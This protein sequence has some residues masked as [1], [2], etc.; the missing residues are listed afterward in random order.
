MFNEGKKIQAGELVSFVKVHPFRFQER[1]LTVKPS[2]QAK[3]REIN[4]DDYVRN[5]YSS[6]S[7][8]FQPMG[9]SLEKAAATLAEFT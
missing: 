4:I 5:L 1:Q 3:M 2:S 8:T 7:Q 9:I 6:L